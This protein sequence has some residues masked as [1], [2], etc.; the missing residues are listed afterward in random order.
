MLFEQF[1]DR[2]E[3][4]FETSLTGKKG[5]S[6]LPEFKQLISL[7]DKEELSSY[8]SLEDYFPKFTSYF[9]GIDNLS[10]DRKFRRLR[11]GLEMIEKLRKIFLMRSAEEIDSLLGRPVSH[12][13]PIKFAYSV[14]EARSKIL[15]RMDI[16]TVG[17][18]IYYFPRDYE[19]RRIIVSI[20]SIVPDCKVSVK[21]RI[22]NF[23]AKKVSGYTIISAVASDGFGQLLLKW[24]NQDYI[25]QKLKKE[26]EYLIHGLAKK[27]A[28]G[29]MEMNSPEIEEVEGEVPR[30]ILPVYSLTSGISMKMMRKVIKRNLGLVRSLDNLVPLPFV[31]SRDLL[32]RRHAFVAIHFPKSQFEIR[33]ARE[34]LA[35]EEFF[36]F[37]TSILY[38]RRQIQNR[39]QGLSKDIS[40]GL[41]KKLI[42]SLPFELTEDQVRAFNEIREDMRASSP[43]SRLLQG[44]VG[45]GKTLVAEL[46]IVDNYEAGYQ[47]ALMVPTSVLAMQHYEKIK[48]DLSPIGI[49]VALLT[50]SMKRSEQDSVRNAMITGEIDLVIGT[51]SL[52]QDGVEF[53][54]LGLVVVDEQHRFGVKQREKL[55][56]K[57]SLLDSLVMT[58]TPIP[59]TLALTAYGDL[60]ISTIRTMPKGRSPVRTVLLARSRLRELY[61]FISDELKM[62]HQVFFIYPLVEESEQVDLKN[63]TDEAARLREQ[64]FPGVGVELL[65]GRFTDTEK[66]EI[67]QRFRTK[68]SMILVSTTVVEVGID[69]PSATV[70]V[71]EHPERFGMAQLHQLRGRVGRSSLK[72]ICVMV[73]NRAIS[74]EALARLREFAS[75]SSGFDVA[76]LDLKLRGPGEFLGL[77]QHGIPQFRIG[78][79]VADR[80]LLFKAREDAKKL[81]DKDPELSEHGSLRIEMERVYSEKVNLIE[82]G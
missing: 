51:H 21:G 2:C 48:R 14:G 17:D 53:K 13:T 37:E 49:E 70:M 50:G 82:V 66:Q 12:S 29:P 24:F 76:E 42:Q 77:R 74:E 22:L 46:A 31:K 61:S 10:D 38:R 57:G 44:D 40:G 25:L 75:T 72:S 39:Y 19:D 79:I 1:L 5:V 59:R 20:S 26:R 41:A 47:S 73:M 54:N 55:T 4:L 52:I 71:I 62:G 15:K 69:V 32:D 11:N 35:Y 78:D 64:V 68:K 60:D 67:M 43:M 7:V 16:E 56:S 6:V 63:A 27:T 9:S 81:I 33:K 34:T 30:E 28:F 3:E 23:S 18:L 58:A 36:L 45:S 80:D 65:H 8:A